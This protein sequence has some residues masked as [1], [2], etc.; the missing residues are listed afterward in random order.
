MTSSAPGTAISDSEILQFELRTHSSSNDKE[1][2]CAIYHSL[3]VL[4]EVGQ[5]LTA[6]LAKQ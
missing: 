5:T 3:T 6:A 1:E 2:L 4:S